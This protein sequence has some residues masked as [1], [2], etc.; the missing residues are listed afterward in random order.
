LAASNRAEQYGKL[1]GI[2]QQNIQNIL[3]QQP[4]SLGSQVNQA[5]GDVF[6]TTR[7]PMTGQT[8]VI[9]AGNIGA[10]KSFVSSSVN[11]DP[12]TGQLIFT[13]VRQDGTVE[14]QNLSGG[15]QPMA[16]GQVPFAIQS[17]INYAGNTPFI[18]S[19]N[20]TPQQLPMA[21]S[22]AAQ[23]GVPLLSKEDATKLK[24]ANATFSS[25][26]ALLSTVEQYANKIVTATSPAGIPSQFLST[27]LGSLL[28]TNPDAVLF[29]S[30]ISAF[31]SLLTRAAGEKGVLTDQ[32]VA[33]IINGLPTRT[34]TVQSATKK[35]EALRSIYEATK[36]GVFD[37]YIGAKKPQTQT[38]GQNII[39]TKIGA[40]DNSWFD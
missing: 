30:S 19:G 8:Q 33:R 6:V 20:L 21:Q 1:L 37:S 39:Q 32:D 17:A 24:E 18:D 3:A 31:S 5:T 23:S 14:T 29:D 16:S 40:V 34:D 22:Y 9:N 7:N 27:K 13:G 2:N 4:T 28:K 11:Q 10:Q 35:V 25:A 26:D 36:N 15:G 38:T 12:F